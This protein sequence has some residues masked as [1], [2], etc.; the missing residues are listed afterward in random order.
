[1]INFYE[2]LEPENE[3]YANPNGAKYNIFHPFRILIVGSSGSGKTN[4]LLNLIQKLNCFEKYYLYV[5]LAGDDALYDQILIPK[6][7]TLAE[8]LGID[9]LG[10]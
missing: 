9:L 4:M 3:K 1:M 6:L 5:K 8:K 2:N 10:A 7:T